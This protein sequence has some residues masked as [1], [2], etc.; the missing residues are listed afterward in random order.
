MD[1]PNIDWN[2]AAVLH[3]AAPFNK[4][5]PSPRPRIF[6]GSLITLLNAW[7]IPSFCSWKIGTLSTMPSD[8]SVE[9][10]LGTSLGI[11]FSPMLLG[12]YPGY[13]LRYHLR[14]FVPL[15]QLW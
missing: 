7:R 6:V 10:T 8:A 5:G 15:W 14:Y 11:F 1:D 2:K 4:W 13:H 3:H 9:V 12:Y